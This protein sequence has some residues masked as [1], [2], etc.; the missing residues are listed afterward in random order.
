MPDLVA[1]SPEARIAGG[2]LPALAMAEATSGMG[3]DVVD[4]GWYLQDAAGPAGHGVKQDEADRVGAEGHCAVDVV[5]R[6]LEQVGGSLE[7]CVEQRPVGVIRGRDEG[8][9]VDRDDI[10]LVFVGEC[11]T[12]HRSTAFPGLP[13]VRVAT[14]DFLAD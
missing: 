2:L 6:D 9:K 10:G 8:L 12:R 11:R 5:A 4:P 13:C 14:S 7:Q 1:E 3:E